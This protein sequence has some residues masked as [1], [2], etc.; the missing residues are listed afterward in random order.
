MLAQR[1]FSDSYPVSLQVAAVGIVLGI[2]YWAVKAYQETRPLPGFPVITLDGKDA[3]E[4]WML[5]GNRA[6][7]EGIRRVWNPAN[8]SCLQT[9]SN[10]SSMDLFRS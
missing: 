6:I 10:Y 7:T 8:N 3:K 9:D 4:T 1:I 5:H 2:V